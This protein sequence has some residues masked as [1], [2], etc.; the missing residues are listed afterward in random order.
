MTNWKVTSY[1]YLGA[2][3]EGEA[4]S[5]A[6]LELPRNSQITKLEREGE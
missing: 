4:W 1:Y 2:E 6:S 5:M 3:S